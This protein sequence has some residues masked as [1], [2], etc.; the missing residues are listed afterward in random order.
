MNRSRKQRSH[1]EEKRKRVSAPVPS[2][3]AVINLIR[4]LLW[5]FCLY[6]LNLTLYGSFALIIWWNYQSLNVWYY[7][8]AHG[9]K[10][11]F[12]NRNCCLVF[13]KI[14]HNSQGPVAEQQG[15]S[16]SPISVSVWAMWRHIN[17]Y[18]W[19]MWVSSLSPFT[20]SERLLTN[21]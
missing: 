19:G 6:R 14:T 5:C 8:L 17:N 16:T 20:F 3:P 10:E 4:S 15:P 18:Q 13:L 2:I 12:Y 1:R 21:W 7:Q 11:A 9:N